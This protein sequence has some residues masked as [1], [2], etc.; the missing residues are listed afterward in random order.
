[1]T[2]S[3]ATG[4]TL[5]KETF[6]EFIQRLKYSYSEKGCCATSHPVF[7]VREKYKEWGIG[8]DYN[9]D[10]WAYILDDCQFF[11]KSEFIQHLS[12]NFD[13]SS[14]EAGQLNNLLPDDLLEASKKYVEGGFICN[15]RIIERV[16]GS[17]FTIE[18]AEAFIKRKQHDYQKLF[19]YVESAYWCW[20]FKEIVTALL[21]DRLIYQEPKVNWF[22]RAYQYL[23][24][25]LS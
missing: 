17:H 3:I 25:L 7:Q 18:A 20:E 10:G 19:V 8:D 4:A 21:D 2:K 23:S 14:E 5:T 11:S 9:N 12:D 6:D 1:M 24:T 15:Y 22:K 16:I 13:L